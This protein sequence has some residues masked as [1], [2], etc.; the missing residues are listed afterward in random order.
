MDTFESHEVATFWRFLESSLDTFVRLANE[1]GDD[2]LQWKP[3]AESANSIAVLLTHTLGNARENVL[4]ILCG[5][6]VN[7]DRESEFI[8]R[9][10]TAQLLVAEWHELRVQ[11]ASILAAVPVAELDRVRS[12]PRRGEIDGRSI[13]I[14]ATRHAAEHLGQAE[15]T[16][17]LWLASRA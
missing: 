9:P 15:L 10:V 17:D 11:L 7:R 3:P 2:A 12:H 5:E 14:V 16:R 13:L 1:I 8:D 6:A 4:E